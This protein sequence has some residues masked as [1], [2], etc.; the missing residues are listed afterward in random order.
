MFRHLINCLKIGWFNI[1]LKSDSSLL[2]FYFDTFECLQ[3]LEM[4]INK[5]K[6]ECKGEPCLVKLRLE[7]YTVSG[8]WLI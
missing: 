2:I 5:F 8:H 7:T 4:K 6:F 3:Q 1:A